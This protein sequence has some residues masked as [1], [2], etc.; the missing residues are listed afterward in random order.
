MNLKSKHLVF[1]IPLLILGTYLEAQSKA[2]SDY[3]VNFN[4]Q[5]TKNHE[6]SYTGSYE[7]GSSGIK[8]ISLYYSS[9]DPLHLDAAREMFL[10]FA[11]EFLDGLNQ[12]ARLRSQLEP[13]PFSEKG[14]DLVIFFR[15]KKG[16]Y[17]K[18][19]YVGQITMKGGVITYSKFVQGKF[20]IIKQESYNS[21]HK[22]VS[23]L[24]AS[25]RLAKSL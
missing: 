7:S 16:N 4:N 22:L 1:L 15:D 14:L 3:I 12:S 10:E 13:Y 18:S 6:V 24:E 19:P 23:R 11:D 25:A 5:V 2:L 21:A 17:A 9:S 20:E 8:E